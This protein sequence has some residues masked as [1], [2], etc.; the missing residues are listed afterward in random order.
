MNSL[1]GTP[2]PPEPRELIPAA[3][4]E[5][6]KI[7]EYERLDRPN[8]PR[9]MVASTD[10]RNPEH[11]FAAKSAAPTGYRDERWGALEES[12]G[13]WKMFGYWKAEGVGS[14]PGGL[15]MLAQFGGMF[16]SLFNALVNQQGLAQEVHCSSQ[17]TGGFNKLIGGFLE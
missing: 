14:A 7:P 8:F 6:M 12:N 4:V 13:Q 1:L 3:P 17:D 9:G 15:K 5:L 11:F 10:I 16:N 2:S